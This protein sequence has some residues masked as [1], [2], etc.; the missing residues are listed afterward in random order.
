MDRNTDLMD[1][2]FEQAPG[3]SE[4]EGSLVRCMSKDSDR[5]EQWNNNSRSET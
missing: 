1:I 2:E 4:R 3:D 5:T